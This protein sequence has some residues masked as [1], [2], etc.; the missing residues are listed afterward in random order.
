M[1][2]ILI[3]I[4]IAICL[5]AAAMLVFPENTSEPEDIGDLLTVSLSDDWE[6]SDLKESEND[7]AVEMGFNSNK[8]DGYL[9]VAIFSYKGKD[10]WS[11]PHSRISLEEHVAALDDVR[12]VEINDD[13]YYIGTKESDDMPDMMILAYVEKGDYVFEF[14]LSNSDDQVT[15]GQKEAFPAILDGVKYKN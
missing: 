9:A 7:I 3:S 2:K 1:K 6:F 11:K 13:T 10:V 15:D 12:Q 4:V 14:R 8:D 5:I